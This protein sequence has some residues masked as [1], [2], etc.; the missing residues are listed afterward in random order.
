MVKQAVDSAVLSF[1][2]LLYSCAVLLLKL[3]TPIRRT[4]SAALCASVTPKFEDA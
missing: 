4:Q 1:F 3:R 2:S